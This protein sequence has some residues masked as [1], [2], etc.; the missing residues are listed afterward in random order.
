M[1]GGLSLTA[2]QAG[3]TSSCSVWH[4]SG[5]YKS[6]Y[7]RPAPGIEV[8]RLPLVRSLGGCSRAGNLSH[9]TASPHGGREP[10]NDLREDD[11][12]H[13]GQD[14]GDHQAARPLVD[15]HEAHVSVGTDHEGDHAHRREDEPHGYH[16]HRQHAEPDG[17][18]P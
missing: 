12:E 15:L 8:G 4:T 2:A 5:I 1:T 10:E 3:I 6:T 11:D 7:L 14:E 16:Q 17:I 13:R 9:V 18:E